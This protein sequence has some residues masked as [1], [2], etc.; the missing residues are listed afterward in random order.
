MSN[1][2]LKLKTNLYSAMKFSD[3]EVLEI[4]NTPVNRI[5]STCTSN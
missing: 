1:V 3:S 4:D 5:E 2:K